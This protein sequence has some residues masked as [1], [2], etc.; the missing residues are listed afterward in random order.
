LPSG[1]LRYVLASTGGSPANIGSEARHRNS[2]AGGA[3]ASLTGVREA[4][5]VIRVVVADRQK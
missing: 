3:D 1:V 2:L 5:D 4:G